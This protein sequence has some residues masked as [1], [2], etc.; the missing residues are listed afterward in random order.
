MSSVFVFLL[1]SRSITRASVRHRACGIATVEMLLKIA[2][3]L[4]S[5]PGESSSVCVRGNFFE[6]D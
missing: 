1:K 6:L 4:V 5:C 2:A 3:C